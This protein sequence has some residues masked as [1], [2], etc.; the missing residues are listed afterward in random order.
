MKTPAL[1]GMKIRRAR[2]SKAGAAWTFTMSAA[3]FVFLAALIAPSASLANKTSTAQTDNLF[4]ELKENEVRT[5][6]VDVGLGTHYFQNN[7]DPT[8]TLVNHWLSLRG[9]PSF[10]MGPSTRQAQS[11]PGLILL[12]RTHPEP[13]ANTTCVAPGLSIYRPSSLLSSTT[14]AR[15]PRWLSQP[16]Y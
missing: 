5:F 3:I 15:S 11:L 16:K 9:T 1:D 13:S 6:A 4:A 8:E 7:I 14:R 10:R 2:E 12:I